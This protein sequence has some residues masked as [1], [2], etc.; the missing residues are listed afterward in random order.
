M[1]TIQ[2][3][4]NKA[5]EQ[6]TDTLMGALYMLDAKASK[7]EAER[8]TYAAISDTISERHNLDAH[9]DAIFEDVTFMGTYAEALTIALVVAA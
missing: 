9:L 8:I 1:T 4:K 3:L 6:S 2:T 7:D 5:T